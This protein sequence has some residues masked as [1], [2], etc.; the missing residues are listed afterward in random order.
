MKVQTLKHHRKSDNKFVFTFG[1]QTVTITRR[2]LANRS[3]RVRVTASTLSGKGE[4]NWTEYRDFP[5]MAQ[6]DIAF[7][8]HA[9]SFCNKWESRYCK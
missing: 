2:F 4:G 1:A 7:N 9:E 8:K 5:N 3:V 6:G